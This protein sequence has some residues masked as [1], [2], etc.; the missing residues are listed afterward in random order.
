MSA[1][2]SSLSTS[3]SSRST[4][5]FSSFSFYPLQILRF[6]SF[7]FVHD[8]IFCIIAVYQNI[9][10]GDTV[11]NLENKMKK[12]LEEN[13]VLKK[14][15]QA[16]KETLKNINAN[17]EI[18]P[19][20]TPS[21]LQ[22]KEA[23]IKSRIRL[24]RSLFWG[25]EDVFATRWTSKDGKT[26][27]SPAREKNRNDKSN[28]KALTDQVIYDHLTG[29]STIGVYPLFKDDTCRFL[30]ID[31]DKQNWKKDVLILLNVCDEMGIP[32]NLERSRSGN[33]GHVWIFFSEK[34]P[35]VLARKLGF[36]LVDKMLEK[37]H[38]TGS[39]S[40][41]RLFPNQ[42][43]LPKGGFGNLIAFP[44][45]HVP[46]KNNN[47]VFVDRNFNVYPDQWLYLSKVKKMNH[48][49][50]NRVVKLLNHGKS[51]IEVVNER[52]PVLQKTPDQLQVILS[53]GIYISK[54]GLPL[55]LIRKLTN[56]AVFNNPAYFK[57]QAR[58]LSVHN[59][60]RKINCSEEDEN[61]LVLPRGCLDKVKE[62]LKEGS[63]D[64]VID[65]QTNLG[66]ELSIKFHGRLT[67]QQEDAVQQMLPYSTGILS[68]STGFG[69]T[70]VAASIIANR[71]V[72]TLVIV[73]RK[74]LMEQWKLQLAMFLNIAEK[75]IGLIGGGE[76]TATGQIDIATM[77]TLNHRGMVKDIVTQ[78]GQVIVDECH[79][80]AAFS[81]ENVL[82]KVKARYVHGLTATPVRKD[83]LH[84]IMEM[85][86]G[87]IRY[88]VNA[89]DQAKVRPFK[90]VL[91]P[92][93]T[94]FKS[95]QDRKSV[96]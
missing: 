29:K 25:R 67:V 45:Q 89:K 22:A 15:N 4:C 27:Y 23:K 62:L 56:L 77:Q 71:N 88:R 55:A 5:F 2:V 18:K 84:P 42:D 39:G 64:I 87:S 44:L 58:R 24:F 66:L 79:R 36:L 54:D 75:D 50:I 53:N 38:Q 13:K 32:A 68:A 91:I 16:L 14:E 95:E 40:Y 57:A 6:L 70:V 78:Y 19:D 47:S 48:A 83:G 51:T 63:I 85:Q 43:Q 60:P 93:Y 10:L 3:K 33:G 65:D 37:R 69:K 73:H 59:I 72:N 26:G 41:D 90:H 20:L 35:A 92:R 1:N 28:Y 76:N 52:K 31:F 34:V 74:Q 9:P 11:T 30:A 80:V 86:C 21:Q 49:D 81:F 61:Y 82:K 7:K 96:V 17:V 8:R 94:S 12:L 46:R